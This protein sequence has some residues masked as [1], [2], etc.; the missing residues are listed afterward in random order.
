MCVC[1]CVLQLLRLMVTMFRIPVET[2][3]LD[4]QINK[5]FGVGTKSMCLV[6]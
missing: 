3:H 5:S 2:R 6:W 4:D 1:V